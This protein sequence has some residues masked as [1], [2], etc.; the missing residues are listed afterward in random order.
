MEPQDNLYTKATMSTVISSTCKT[1]TCMHKILNNY[2]CILCVQDLHNLC[3]H[4]IFYIKDKNCE[5]KALNDNVQTSYHFVCTSYLKKY[6]KIKVIFQ[7]FGGS[8]IIITIIIMHTVQFRNELI[9]THIHYHMMQL[10]CR[11]L[12]IEVNEGGWHDFCYPQQAWTPKA[13]PLNAA[14]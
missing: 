6:K 4:D 3:K 2:L 10:Q 13:E 7:D 12:C 11:L 5:H 9:R 1:I 14:Y 8:V